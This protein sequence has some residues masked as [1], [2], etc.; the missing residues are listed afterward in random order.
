[1]ILSLMPLTAWSGM[2]DIACR[3]SNGEI[4]LHCPML[5]QPKLVVNHSSEGIAS[6]GGDRRSCCGGSGASRHCCQTAKRAANK[7]EN[8]SPSCCA[9]T[10]RCTPIIVEGNSGA[11]LKTEDIPAFSDVDFVQIAVLI[12]R[13][14]RLTR[15]DLVVIDSG[16]DRAHDL[17]V[18][19]ERFLI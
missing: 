14:P 1:M 11:K 2:P 16:P 19:F 17:I 12:V 15:T 10:C 3:C 13:L 6:K 8:Q 4:R 5:N 7:S 9:E 18:L